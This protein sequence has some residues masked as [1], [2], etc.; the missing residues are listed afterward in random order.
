MFPTASLMRNNLL[1]TACR[2]R[3]EERKGHKDAQKDAERHPKS[4]SLSEAALSDAVGPLPGN[5]VN[6]GLALL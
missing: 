4:R 3:I 1:N 2:G 6:K 5:K